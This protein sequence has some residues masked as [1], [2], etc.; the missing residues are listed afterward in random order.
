MAWKPSCLPMASINNWPGLF[1]PVEVYFKFLVLAAWTKSLKVL[2]G[3]SLLTAKMT[4]VR[5]RVETG[6]KSSI[7]KSAFLVNMERDILE[8]LITRKVYPS[9]L[10]FFT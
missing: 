3:L 8:I 4:E 7:V 9:G 1:T 10:L 2:Y 6:T 5:V